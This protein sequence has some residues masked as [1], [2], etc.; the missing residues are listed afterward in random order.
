CCTVPNELIYVKSAGRAFWSHNSPY[1]ISYPS[2][3]YLESLQG[4][5]KPAVI[6]GGHHHKFNHGY[7]REVTYI[8]CGCVQDQTPF[9]RT[10]K[11]QAMVGGVVLWLKQNSLGVF[12]SV[13]AEWLPYYDKKFYA[14]H[15]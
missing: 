14:F 13:K 5:E 2:Q 7:P 6:L 10:R 15:W 9:M 8:E 3:K 4:G 11:I 1:A 12:T